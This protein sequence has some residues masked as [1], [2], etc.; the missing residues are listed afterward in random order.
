[1]PT[2]ESFAAPSTAMLMAELE[3]LSKLSQVVASTSELQPILDWIVRETTALLSAD[4]GTIRLP[5]PA[6][7]GDPMKTRVRRQARGAESGSWPPAVSL[8][9]EG[10]LSLETGP[11]ATPDLHADPRFPGLRTPVTRVRAL[12][13]VSLRVEGRITGMLAVTHHEPGRHWMPN[14]IQLLTIVANSS[15]S[16]LEQARLRAE[17][18]ERRRLAELTRRMEEELDQAR[19]I[20]MGLV[21][22]RPLQVGP[23]LA[24][25]RIQPARQ[26]GGDAFSYY[27]LPPDRM[28]VAIADVSGKGVPASLL[29]SSVQASL[30]AFCDG[31]WPIPEAMRQL[32]ESVARAAQGG[33]FITLFYA[34]IDAAARRLRYSNAGHNFPMLRRADGSLELLRA[35]GLPLGIFESTDFEMGEVGFTPGDSLLL[36]SDGV[37]EALN[38]REEEFGEERLQARWSEF[39]GRP[40]GEVLAALLGEVTDF[41]GTAV[42]SDDIT[43]V[44]VGAA[45]TS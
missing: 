37:S 41:R 34:E 21:P 36:Y 39:G 35:G 1:M 12:L 30:R 8:S 32:N 44:V 9:V 19:D 24:A 38:P 15:A 13:A 10:F 5:D 23:W 11:L 16:V 31:R 33:K 27:A 2:G 7:A 3:F 25:G 14:E 43:L 17:A 18:V 22:K 6:T 20:Q 26:V 29:M 40:P 28:A 4:E 42:Q 45:G